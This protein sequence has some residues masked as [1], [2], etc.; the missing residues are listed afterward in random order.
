MTLLSW[1]RQRGGWAHRLDAR[2]AGWSRHSIQAASA[3]GEIA[4]TARAWLHLPDPPADLH[5]AMR[6][7][8][9]VTCVSALE[10]LGLWM[11]WRPVAADG[12]AA[13]RGPNPDPPRLAPGA[14]ARGG[15]LH[16]AIHP[17]AGRSAGGVRLHRHLGPVTAPPRSLVD[18]LENV[19]A[20]VATCLCR[21]DALTVWESAIA[22]GLTTT[23]HLRTMPWTSTNARELAAAASSLSDSG[24]ETIVLHALA[25]TGVEALQQVQILGHDVDLL[26]GRR[27]VVQLDGFA[28]H[29]GAD[30]RRDIAHDRR[31]RLAGYTVLRYDWREVHE[32]LPRVLAEIRRA[33][34]Q[35]LHRAR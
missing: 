13:A 32:E 16:L 29:R 28:H 5:A 2:A 7:G 10:R 4:V 1:M 18:P 20:R 34:A 33:M 19:L 30:R 23:A 31:L 35:G 6:L 3:R 27:L 12:S 14:A 21:E 8:A 15:A 11:P 25:R 22:R 26:I 9:R 17:H 24:L